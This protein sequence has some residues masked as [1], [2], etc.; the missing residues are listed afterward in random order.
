LIPGFSWFTP[1]VKR[2]SGGKDNL[3]KK[4]AN[5]FSPLSLFQKNL[6]TAPVWASRPMGT[7]LHSYL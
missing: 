2:P 7:T 4:I 3:L 1:L 6:R 5:T